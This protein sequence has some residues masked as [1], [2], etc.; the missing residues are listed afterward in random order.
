MTFHNLQ[1]VKKL[2]EGF[3]LLYFEETAKNGKTLSGKEKFWHV[4]HVVAK[5]HHSTK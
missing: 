5:K 4:F 1:T 3:E 2:F